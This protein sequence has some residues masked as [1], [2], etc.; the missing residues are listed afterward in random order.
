[1][2]EGEE[3]EGPYDQSPKEEISFSS[4]NN[5]NVSENK[6]TNFLTVEM[7]TNQNL[8]QTKDYQHNSYIQDG[9]LGLS[10]DPINQ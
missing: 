6:H 8:T 7:T 4:N 1:M 10:Q 3:D 5:K 9:E 2:I